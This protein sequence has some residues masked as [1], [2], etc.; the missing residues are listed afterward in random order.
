MGDE[1]E[2]LGVDKGVGCR[3]SF[4]LQGD[5]D[6]LLPS[7]LRSPNLLDQSVNRVK[8]QGDEVTVN[9]RNTAR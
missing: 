4:I 5:G 8:G 2:G 6:A 9:S 1:G 7:P 3:A